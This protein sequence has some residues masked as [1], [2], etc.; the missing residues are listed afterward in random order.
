MRALPGAR[1]WQRP[2]PWAAPATAK[3]GAKVDGADQEAEEL[4]H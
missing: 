2:G 4:G 1:A 3:P